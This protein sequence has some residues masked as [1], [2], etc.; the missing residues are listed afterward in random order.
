MTDKNIAKT[1]SSKCRKFIKA[2][3][4]TEFQ[5]DIDLSELK[6]E[7]QAQ[8]EVSRDNLHQRLDNAL[9][10]LSEDLYKKKTH[11]V[12]ELIQ[13]ADDNAY[14]VGVTPCF[15]ITI[16]PNRLVVFNNERGFEEPNVKALCSVGDS[17][18][19]K[20][21]GYIGEKGIGFKSVFTVSDRPEIHSNGFHF[22]Y[23]RSNQQ[24]HLGFVVPE[25][26]DDAYATWPK[27]GT[28]IVLPAK[29]GAAFSEKMLS[30]ITPE[31]LL[32]LNK[33]KSIR[34]IYQENGHEN[35]SYQLTNNGK[36]DQLAINRR[37]AGA[38]E[39]QAD[40][41]RFLKL[42]FPISMADSPDEGKRP[43]ITE[44]NIV[45]AFPLNADGS[46][47][48]ASPQKVF[49]F[50]PIDSFGFRF[51]VQGDFLL[52]TN[53]EGIHED[54]PW[55][56]AIRD[57]IPENF[58]LSIPYFRENKRLA[59]SFLRFVPKAGEITDSFFAPV[60]SGIVQKL[61]ECD[62]VLT[63]SGNWRK[64]KDVFVADQASRELISNADL[65]QILGKEFIS[66]EALAPA[67]T[68]KDI[69]CSTFRPRH[70]IECLGNRDWAA[71]RT[72]AWFTK[73]FLYLTDWEINEKFIRLVEPTPCFRLQ[74]GQ[75]AS[76]SEGEIFFPLKGKTI[77]GFEKELRVLSSAVFEAPS[78][79]VEKVQQLLQSLGIRPTSARY[80][81]DSHILPFHNGEKWKECAEK[82]LLGHV[83]Y[84]KENLDQYL[85][86]KTSSGIDTP[87]IRRTLKQELG[88]QLFLKTKAVEGDNQIYSRASGLYL[89]SDYLPQVDIENLLGG[90]AADLAS[91]LLSPDYLGRKEKLKSESASN[92]HA[93]RWREFYLSIGVAEKPRVV[94]R[95]LAHEGFDYD[96]DECLKAI[97]ENVRQRSSFVEMLDR[98][99]GS[100]YR[101][102]QSATEYYIKGRYKYPT[103][104]PSTFL[105]MIRALEVPTTKRD[106]ARIPEC[107]LNS[108]ELR[109]VFG[110]A[111]SFIHVNVS[112]PHFMEAVGI[113]GK[114]DLAACLKRLSQL[115]KTE[116]PSLRSIQKV[117]LII[118]TLADRHLA[119]VKKEFSTEALIYVP[120]ADPKWRK[121][122]SVCWQSH[123]SLLDRLYPPL[124][125]RYR[126][127]HT[128]FVK[129]VG[130][131]YTLSP[132]KLINGLREL[133]GYGESTEERQ[134][135]GMDI[136]RKLDK[137]LRDIRAKE[138]GANEPD[139]IDE[140]RD[141]K[142]LLDTKGRLCEPG[143]G[144]Y[145]DDRP[146]VA[147]FFVDVD[148]VSFFCATQGQLMLVRSLIEA[149]RIP[150]LSESM[151]RS[152]GDVNVGAVDQEL[153]RL[154]RSRAGHIIRILHFK[155]LSVFEQFIGQGKT[156]HL[157]SV[158][159]RRPESLSIE[160][161][162][163]GHVAVS[164]E[165]TFWGGSVILIK[166][167][168]RGAID[169]LAAELCRYINLK[170][171]VADLLSL[172]LRERDSDEVEAILLTRGIAEIP[173]SL[174][175]EIKAQFRDSVTS[176][177]GR[178]RADT[179]SEEHSGRWKTVPSKDIERPVVVPNT[180][181]H[182]EPGRPETRP[183]LHTNGGSQFSGTTEGTGARSNDHHHIRQTGESGSSNV[184]RNGD[185]AIVSP[186]SGVA[187]TEH[188]EPDG[189]DSAVGAHN[190]GDRGSAVESANTG[191]HKYSGAK[192]ETPRHRNRDTYKKNRGRLR[193]YVFG[194]GGDRNERSDGGDDSNPEYMQVGEAA[195][196]W[197]VEIET[198]EGRLVERMP[199][200]NEGFD[201]LRR[202]ES[203]ES[204]YIE[205]KGTRGPW[206]ESG[207]IVRPAQIRFASKHGD[208]F[209]LY[210]VE[211]ALDPRQRRLW[212][213]KDPF[214]QATEFMFDSGWK[215]LAD[216][217]AVS[218][219]KPEVGY[220]IEIPDKGVGEITQVIKKGKF[221]KLHVRLDTGDSVF[222][223]PFVPGRMKLTPR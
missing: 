104:R 17:T 186:A 109:D 188:A 166:A 132:E 196:Q 185:D 53:R 1:D 14:D 190:L 197:V 214:G 134:R 10:L 193:S 37:R 173:E 64:P 192:A 18:K 75:L 96:G 150:R 148:D 26:I 80:I 63:E 145:I 30:E 169:K 146:D 89:S 123:G 167:G 119:E 68:L 209:W 151:A 170:S 73:F 56:H 136:Y 195:A 111:V 164:Q 156:R 153:T 7:K 116:K 24:S 93:E 59:R 112:D 86:E 198:N 220:Q 62:C 88:N 147:K 42:S 57:A 120:D 200:E 182:D 181:L 171:D 87:D 160:I 27:D 79:K 189:R 159:V 70:L 36:L 178:D 48:S 34:I 125:E 223:N 83:R 31:A 46:A 149:C 175:D 54:R 126:E 28:T 162:L 199:H 43:G 108:D 210:V 216:S 158:T 84:V 99:W 204:E 194:E 77:Y 49:A 67:E 22:R 128:F 71:S 218:N 131:T 163:N 183:P 51:L 157:Q 15:E 110:D 155:D 90:K 127:F 29:V 20:Q 121:A 60:A 187:P 107:F 82:V 74:S 142:L 117:Y 191:Y 11:F 184:T 4:Q 69:G 165:D 40:I 6:R 38:T 213:I 139:W 19:E 207:V 3:R 174:L 179:A 33:L 47:D 85:S 211:Y 105:S 66:H 113:V 92:E 21:E 212:R 140:I 98:Y 91:S 129:K 12:L 58:A 143:D 81:I 94:K 8:L 50:L 13:N 201:V 176:E 76:L 16:T 32:F 41:H 141:G 55:N 161:S 215:K 100:Y 154:V 95:T 144:L 219:D 208:K 152:I 39:S 130:I 78:D 222:I 118:A 115:S 23:D 65:N 180:G 205:V 72:D 133:E 217:V 138:Q 5:L 52:T 106:K 102:F 203:G 206:T 202:S 114:V 122:E 45:L 135:A 137:I 35:V 44:S 172:I 61:R 2:L 124:E 97:A 9:R 221:F 101:H 168:V 25:W 177:T 103:T